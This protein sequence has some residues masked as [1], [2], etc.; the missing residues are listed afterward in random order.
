ME[1]NKLNSYGIYEEN[2]YEQSHVTHSEFAL[3]EKNV[4]QRFTYIEKQLEEIKEEIKESR[5]DLR[6]H[7]RWLIGSVV[8]PSIAIAISVFS[9]IATFFN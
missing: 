7:K 9:L 1:N 6:E 2:K 4:D 3:N 8:V 5:K